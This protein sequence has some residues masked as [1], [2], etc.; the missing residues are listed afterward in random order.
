LEKEERLDQ[1]VFR[2]KKAIKEELEEK[3]MKV[4]QVLPENQLKVIEERWVNKA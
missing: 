4:N 3:E 2:E 1:E